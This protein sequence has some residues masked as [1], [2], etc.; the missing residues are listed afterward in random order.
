MKQLTKDELFRI[1]CFGDGSLD[2]YVR[3]LEAK[4]REDIPTHS[5]FF[6]HPVF[7][8]ELNQK[9]NHDQ[10]LQDQS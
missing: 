10:H 5:P 8:P 6:Y 2:S 1:A 3:A 4:A 9:E 7:K